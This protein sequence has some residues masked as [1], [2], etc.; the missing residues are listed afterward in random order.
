MRVILF[1]SIALFTVFATGG[2][3]A[4]PA[5]DPVC[6]GLATAACSSNASCSWVK[7]Y[8]TKKGKDV[9]GFCRKKVTKKA[10]PAK[11]SS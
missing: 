4:A 9:A 2:L 1:A 8:K 6:K 10:T 3:M 7:P 5:A 11:T